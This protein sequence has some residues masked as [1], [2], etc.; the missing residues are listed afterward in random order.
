MS[1]YEKKF[2]ELKGRIL[3]IHP[4]AIVQSGII[5]DNG[6]L[7]FRTTIPG[8]QIIENTNI[9]ALAIIVENLEA[10]ARMKSRPT[11]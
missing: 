11:T 7:I 2:E 4:D 10:K 5:G 9:N 8:V 1:E 3:K 6:E